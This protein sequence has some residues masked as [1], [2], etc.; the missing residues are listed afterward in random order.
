MHQGAWGEEACEKDAATQKAERAEECMLKCP[1]TNA[2]GRWR[3]HPEGR[4]SKVFL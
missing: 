2:D 1:P 3:G 4:K